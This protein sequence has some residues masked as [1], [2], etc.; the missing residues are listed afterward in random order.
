MTTRERG[1][2]GRVGQGRGNQG[3]QGGAIRVL[4]QNYVNSAN[5][6]CEFSVA[7]GEDRQGKRAS[8]IS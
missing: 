6:V 3:M 4:C 5:I 7:R 2:V 8:D 1:G